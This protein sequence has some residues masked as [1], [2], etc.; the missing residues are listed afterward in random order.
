[1][2]RI[3]TYHHAGFDMRRVSN[4]D[5]VR[6]ECAVIREAR[7]LRALACKLAAYAY[8]QVAAYRVSKDVKGE[9][10]PASS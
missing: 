8:W 2:N 9:G 4:A 6:D 7:E 5:E 1:M 10:Q 3:H